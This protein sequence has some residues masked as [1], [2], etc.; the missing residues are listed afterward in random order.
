MQD[1]QGTTDIIINQNAESATSTTN[2]PANSEI[3]Q[4]FDTLLAEMDSLRHDFDTK[5]KY[6]ESKERLID[7]LHLELQAYREGLHFKILR[8]LFLDLITMYDDLGKVVDDM[9]TKDSNSSVPQDIQNFASF[10]ET[11]EEILRRNGVDV[12]CL[13]DNIFVVSQQ[14]VLKV[15]PT[16][17][18]SQDKHIARRVR[19]GFLYENRVLRPEI[20]DIYKYVPAE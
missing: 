20:V 1:Q 10:Q 17:N 9:Q 4:R 13:E 7:T 2:T 8:P 16:T 18:P 15:L 11:I 5:V 14:R 3:I 19:K 12:F 6:D